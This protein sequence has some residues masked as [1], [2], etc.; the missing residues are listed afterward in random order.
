MGKSL[1]TPKDLAD[2]ID[3]S[4]SSMRRWIDSG[5]IRTTRTGGGHR[6]IELAEAIRFVRESNWPIVRPEILNVA[7]L[8][9]PPANETDDQRL[10]AALVSGDRALARGLI[11]SWYVSGKNLATIFDGPVSA[12]L[13]RVGELW[14][15]SDCGVLVE[16][17]ASEICAEIIRHVASLVPV[18]A[19][20]TAAALGA[21]PGDEWHWLPSLMAAAVVREA[22]LRDINYGANLPVELLASAAAEN[23]AKLVWISVTMKP[24]RTLRAQLESLAAKLAKNATALVVGGRHAPD[25]CPA[26]QPNVYCMNSMTELAAFIGGMIKR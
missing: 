17:R 20:A 4:E 6:R 12:A 25:A 8:A 10:Y 23:K 2:A 19:A 21:T 9:L 14:K 15:E 1:L 7:E 13:T 24:K 26:D 11:V 22:G 18:A 5:K 16:H 3:T